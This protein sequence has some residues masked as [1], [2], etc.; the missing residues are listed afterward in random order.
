MLKV[1]MGRICLYIA[2]NALNHD[3]QHDKYADINLQLQLTC[4]SE[5]YVEYESLIR[6]CTICSNNHTNTFTKSVSI[7]SKDMMFSKSTAVPNSE[8]SQS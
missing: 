6:T 8:A 7:V 5:E 1:M 4:H 3:K 2:M